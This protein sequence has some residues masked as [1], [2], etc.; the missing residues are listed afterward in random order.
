MKSVYF[1]YEI[2][3]YNLSNSL[4]IETTRDYRQLYSL[5]TVYLSPEDYIHEFYKDLI[6]EEAY[7]NGEYDVDFIKKKFPY[8]LNKYFYNSD[9]LNRY[10]FFFKSI[11]T[12][13]KILKKY[14]YF[15]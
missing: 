11:Q 14:S 2:P 6:S 9:I 1:K 5:E 8:R 7:S 12:G 3:T 13:P 4:L 15:Y 10:N